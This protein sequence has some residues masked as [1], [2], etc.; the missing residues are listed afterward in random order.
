MSPSTRRRS[1][2]LLGTGAALLT[3]L[4]GCTGVPKTGSDDGQSPTE[5]VPD[6]PTRGLS[7]TVTAERTIT[8][9]SGYGDGF[10]YF[11]DNRTVRLVT[12]R[13]GGEPKRFETMPAA[14][15]VGFRAG[16]TALER[17]LEALAGRIDTGEPGSGVG[18]P[19]DGTDT[20]GPAVTLRADSAG[21]DGPAAPYPMVVR[22]APRTVEVTVSLDATSWTRSVPVFVTVETGGSA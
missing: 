2:R 10:R 19:P 12:L 18:R 22:A 16:E 4:A 5:S 1:L 21:A 9:E 6:P 17:V 3:G 15:W 8:D 20:D 13:S 7:E 14:E 11:A